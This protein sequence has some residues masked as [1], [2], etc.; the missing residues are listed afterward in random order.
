MSEIRPMLAGERA[1]SADARTCVR[2][3]APARV[4]VLQG[5]SQGQP[6]RVLY[7][8]SCAG[9]EQPLALHRVRLRRRRLTLPVLLAVCGVGLGL[10]A[11]FA[12]AL[13]PAAQSGFGRHQQIGVVVG[14]LL[15]FFG[16]VLRT[17]VIGIIGTFIFLTA[18]SADLFGEERSPGMGWKQQ[19]IF[20]CALL[21]VMLAVFSR[22]LTMLIYSRLGSVNGVSARSDNSLRVRRRGA[23]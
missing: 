16:T 8:L 10:V 14:A 18:L 11:V 22:P 2:C 5:Y 3:E 7:C 23:S 15:V 13:F 4:E 6:V 20:G 1:T 17:D 19:I 21:L 12:D 9:V